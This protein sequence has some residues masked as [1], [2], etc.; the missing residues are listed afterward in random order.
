MNKGLL[1][2]LSGPSG[3]GKGTVRESLMM[4]QELNLAYSVSMTTRPMRPGEV[5]GRDYYFVD[6]A[7]FKK[8]VKD[9][10]FLEHT[11]FVKHN[12]GTLKSEVF[13]LLEQGKNVLLEIEV[14]GARQVMNEIDR[15]DLLTIFLLP[16]SYDELE[17][18]IRHRSTE[19]EPVIEKRL[20]KAKS[21]M[22]MARGYNYQVV[23]DDVTRVSQEIVSILQKAFQERA[24]LTTL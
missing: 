14:N 22:E 12:Y 13:S 24:T 11:S 4:H 6:D 9:K 3:V 5:E 17:N 15:N 21:E 18:R 8:A 23:N 20:A 19:P 2:I 7:T 10:L 1:V 16:P